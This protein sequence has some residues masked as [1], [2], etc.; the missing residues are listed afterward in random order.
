MKEIFCLV[1]ITL[2]LSCS[3]DFE[4]IEEPKD[5]PIVYG[6]ISLN[7]SIHYLRVEKAFADETTS[8]LEL[9]KD[10][11]NLYYENAQVRLNGRLL[12]R[13]D[14]NEEGL[15]REEGIFAEAPNYLYK[16]SREE[17]NLSEGQQC[18]FS[19]DRGDD[20]LPEVT[21]ETNIVG[22]PMF[23]TPNPNG[24]G[25]IDFSYNQNTTFG[26]LTGEFAQTFD[27]YLDFKYLEKDGSPGSLFE[28]KQVRW[29]ID[30]GIANTAASIRKEVLGI[31]F[32]SF[33][34]GAIDE[35]PDAERFFLGVDL[36]IV[37][38]GREIA[39]YVRVG[40]ANLGIT[41]SQDVPVYS[42][43]SEGRGI[44][45]SKYQERASNFTLSNRSKDSLISGIITGNLNFQ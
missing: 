26:W 18:R 44:F 45:S 42:N 12:Q 23:I 11:N 6:I 9:A 29:L 32:Y 1:G 25:I 19:L 14:G 16:I 40:E 15:V 24:T 4:I 7:D 37:S 10:P 30:D 3:N 20:N 2:I 21:A 13:V 33:L 34:V 38:G 27:L 22:S 35:N 5:I 39:E 31:D 41:S 28:E 8:A 36:V 17:L 43:I